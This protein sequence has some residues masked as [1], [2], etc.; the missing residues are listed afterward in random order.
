MKRT[1]SLALVLMLLVSCATVY[2]SVVSLTSVIDG[3]AKTYAR[4]Y[5]SGLVPPDLAAK[6]SKAYLG[7]RDSARVAR[8]ALT[9]YKA[10]GD[11]SSYQAALAVARQAAWNFANLLL[12]LLAPHDAIAIQT[13]LGKATTI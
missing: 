4:L 12:P 8:D 7:Y 1:L 11:P 3:A 13:Q 10:S 5:N 9:A 2:T 6:V